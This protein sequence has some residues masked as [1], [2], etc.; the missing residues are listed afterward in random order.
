MSIQKTKAMPLSKAQARM[1]VRM[2]RI[3]DMLSKAIG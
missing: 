3:V 1:S 2:D